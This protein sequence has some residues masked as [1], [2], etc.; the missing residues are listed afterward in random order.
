MS[1]TVDVECSRC[2]GEGEIRTVEHDP[3]WVTCPLCHGVGTVPVAIK[4]AT[5]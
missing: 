4:D 5:P 3:K 2:E 1:Q